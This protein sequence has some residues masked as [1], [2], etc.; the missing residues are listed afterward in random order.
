MTRRKFMNALQII[1]PKPAARIPRSALVFRVAV[2]ILLLVLGRI[3]M[4]R[5]EDGIVAEPDALAE[6]KDS[7][8]NVN[9]NDKSLP[10]TPPADASAAATTDGSGSG[11]SGSGEK[12]A[13]PAQPTVQSATAPPPTSAASVAPTSDLAPKSVDANVRKKASDAIPAR[14]AGSVRHIHRPKGHVDYRSR[15]AA[16]GVPVWVGPPPIVNGPGPYA[17]AP[18]AA[19]SADETKRQDRMSIASVRGAWER[20]VE[21]PRAVLNGGKQALYGVLD[22]IW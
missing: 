11:G 16:D 21:T 19:G 12:V 6:I 1:P 4:S 13:A 20:V 7:R 8:D 9:D 10:V 15:K 5:G 3:G 22:S 18:Y 2:T 14:S 17:R